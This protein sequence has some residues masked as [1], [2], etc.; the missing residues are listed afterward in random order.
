MGIFSGT[1]REC[2]PFAEGMSTT[3]DFQRHF[4]RLI[5][6]TVADRAMWVAAQVLRPMLDLV[7]HLL[8]RIFIPNHP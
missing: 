3:M 2:L 8:S 7:D 5:S 6:L 4:V 1:I